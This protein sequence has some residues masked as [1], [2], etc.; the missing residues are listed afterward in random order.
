MTVKARR[1]YTD[2]VSGKE[3]AVGEHIIINRRRGLSLIAS[4]VVALVSDDDILPCGT[5]LYDAYMGKPEKLQVAENTEKTTVDESTYESLTE[6]F[7][8]S[9]SKVLKLSLNDLRTKCDAL[10]IEYDADDTRAILFSKLSR[11]VK[12]N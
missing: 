3:V 4:G 10:G 9:A 6:V 7:G 11:H 2:K 1:A 12:G 8:I 5:W